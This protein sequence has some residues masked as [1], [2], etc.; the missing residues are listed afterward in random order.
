MREIQG[1]EIEVGRDREERSEESKVFLWLPNLF[2]PLLNSK[3]LSALGILKTR[4]TVPWKEREGEGGGE[5]EWRERVTRVINSNFR[6][7]IRKKRKQPTTKKSK[8]TLKRVW[9]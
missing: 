4:I 6:L 5:R 8:H 9:L 3:S 1:R 7:Q 2:I